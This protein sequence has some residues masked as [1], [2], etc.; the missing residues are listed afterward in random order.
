MSIWFATPLDMPTDGETCWCRLTFWFGT[1][2][3]AVWRSA[4]NDWLSVDN[5]IVYPAW[6]IARWRPV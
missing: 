1:P 4:T 2:F 5:S 6:S 3:Q